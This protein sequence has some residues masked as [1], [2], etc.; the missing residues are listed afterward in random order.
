LRFSVQPPERDAE[1]SE[2]SVAVL[3]AVIRP[4]AWPVALFQRGGDGRSTTAADFHYHGVHQLQREYFYHD[5]RPK[6]LLF[7]SIRL[8]AANSSV[9]F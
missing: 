4:T 3:P 2:P 1:P 8:F 5:I 6:L 9:E 7:L